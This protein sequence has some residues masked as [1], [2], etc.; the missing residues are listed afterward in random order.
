[1]YGYLSEFTTKLPFLPP[2][3]SFLVSL[4]SFFPSLLS[5]ALFPSSFFSFLLLLSFL[6]SF[7]SV[8]CRCHCFFYMIVVI[9]HSISLPDP[10]VCSFTHQVRPVFVLVIDV[11]NSV[12]KLDSESQ[13]FYPC[14]KLFLYSCY[15]NKLKRN[16]K[17]S[18]FFHHSQPFFRTEMLASTNEH[19]Y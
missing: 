11:L 15:I 12:S 1:M 14:G 4:L 9:H 16:S 3:Y 6:P 18:S 8:R 10:S 19:G 2:L 13:D 7:L 5:F 17:F